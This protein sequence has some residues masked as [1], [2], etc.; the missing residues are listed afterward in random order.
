MSIEGITLEHFSAAPQENINST[1]PLRQRHTV[2]QYFLS[3]NSKQYAATTTAHR[4]Q[5]ISLL[6]EKKIY[7]QHH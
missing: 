3:D 4:K 7:L 1:T 5:L 6:K 2:F